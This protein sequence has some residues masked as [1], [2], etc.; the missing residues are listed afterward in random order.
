M[1]DRDDLRIIGQ[2]LILLLTL[3]IV[4]FVLAAMAGLAVAVFEGARGL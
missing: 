1:F 3:A 2:G 4:V